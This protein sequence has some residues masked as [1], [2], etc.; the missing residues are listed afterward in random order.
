MPRTAPAP[1][2]VAIPGMNPGTFVAG[3]GGDGGGG[4]GGKGG[5]RGGGGAGN[6]GPH[7]LP[8]PGAVRGRGDR[9]LLQPVSVLRPRAREV[10][11]RGSGGSAGRHERLLV[12]AEHGDVERPAGV[13]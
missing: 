13:D 10:H 2:M 1:N 6:G 12:R 7:A 8:L 11:Q 9:P 5:G 4:S 3:G